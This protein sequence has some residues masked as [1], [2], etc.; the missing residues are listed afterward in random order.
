MCVL[1]CILKQ[2]HKRIQQ[3]IK[4]LPAQKPYTWKSVQG[5]VVIGRDMLWYRGQLLEV[6][7][8]HVMVGVTRGTF[9]PTEK[10]STSY[11]ISD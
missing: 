11:W 5:C 2:L 3:G 6:L 9:T 7:G 4:T 10:I 1:E 8:G